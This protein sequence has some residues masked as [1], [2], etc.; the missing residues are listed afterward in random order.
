MLLMSTTVVMNMLMTLV[1]RM[2]GWQ[3]QQRSC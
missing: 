2:V 1:G 3:R